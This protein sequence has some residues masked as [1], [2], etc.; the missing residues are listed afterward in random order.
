MQEFDYTSFDLSFF[1]CCWFYNSHLFKVVYHIVY[2]IKQS[3]DV[4]LNE[5]TPKLSP[6]SAN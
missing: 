2:D 4:K 1:G 3:M 6:Q 5:E